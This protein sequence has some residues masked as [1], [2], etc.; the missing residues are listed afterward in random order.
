MGVPL[1][2]TRFVCIGTDRYLVPQVAAG[3]AS[4]PLPPSV[5]EAYRRKCI[6]LKKRMSEVEESNDAFR[7]R[8]L[9]LNR[10]IRKMRLE[11]AYLLEMLSKRMKKNGVGADGMPSFYE[12]DSEGSSEG[13]PTVCPPLSSAYL[14]FAFVPPLSHIV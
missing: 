3:T 4:T 8:K 13:P 14:H 5:E 6:D 12:E 11:R 9:R 7:L 10:G 2:G 1:N